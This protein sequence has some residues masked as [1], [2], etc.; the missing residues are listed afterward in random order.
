MGMP[1]RLLLFP[2]FLCLQSL[3]AGGGRE[4]AVKMLNPPAAPV[5]P[6]VEQMRASGVTT[7]F[8][9]TDRLLT[10]ADTARNL[11]EFRRLLA[12]AGIKFY[13]T[14]PVFC[15]P[16]AVQKDPGL[17]GMGHLGSPSK[18]PGANWNTFV[19]PTRPE[20]RKQR[21]TG[22]VDMVR[23]LRPNGLSLDF[24]RYFVYWERVRP[25]QTGESIE[26]FCFCDHCLRLMQTELG[27]RFP[28]HATT[29]QA[30]AAWVLATQRKKWT[31]WKC[32]EITSMV[33][34]TAAAARGVSPGLRISLHGVPWMEKEYDEGR[35]AIAGQDLKK[36]APYVDMFGPM[37]YFQMLG[38]RPE[39]VHDVA[40]EY[41]RQ[42]GKPT[43]PSLQASGSGQSEAVDDDAFRRHL[44][45]G[46]QSPSEGINL[47][48]W[49]RLAR[50]TKKLTVLQQVLAAAPG[51]T[52]AG[53]RTRA[54]RNV[55]FAGV[56]SSNYGIRPFPPVEG[57]GRAMKTMAGYFPGSTPV[58]IWIVGRLN[59]RSTGMTLEFPHPANRRDY[60]PLY[61]FSD[62]DKH[63][64]YLNYFDASGIKVFLQVEP[65]FADVNTAIDLVLA[66]YKRHRSVIGFGIDVEWFQNARTGGRNAI[67]TDELVKAWEARVKSHKRSYRLFVKHFA[68]DNLPLKYRGDVV[69]VDD[70]QQFKSR[71]HF[72][73]EFGEF[74]DFFYPN[75]VMYQIGYRADKPWWGAAGAP[76]PK[77]LGQQLAANTRQDCGIVWLDFT[78]RDV[79]P[80]GP[81]PAA[82]TNPPNTQKE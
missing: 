32:E 66:R 25:E 46:L 28:G 81:H 31:A 3:A 61:T 57:W 49:D 60:G 65:G 27:L 35:R 76:I 14:A 16:E 1:V 7:V 30:K 54:R 40:A 38:R 74:A 33:R 62:D 19:C 44:L 11:R 42:T 59:G 20:Y 36:L 9:R 37:C 55:R 71:E 26:K 58:G 51:G 43:L 48:S 15:D 21:I 17:L 63:E 39:W 8:C 10:D 78:L 56:R 2:V 77:T 52:A 80:L 53:E 24:I 6:V 12:E 18:A 73:T 23:R 75:T 13:I 22:I 47:F 34:K 4:V 67:A 72:L 29:R 41:Y 82:E 5:A 79:L 64:P 50:D 69:F 70:S 68:I 45:A